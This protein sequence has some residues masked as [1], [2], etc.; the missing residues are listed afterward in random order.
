MKKKEIFL[1]SS[2]HLIYPSLWTKKLIERSILKPAIIDSKIIPHGVDTDIFIPGDK[3]IARDYLKLSQSTFIL[4]MTAKGGFDNQKFDWGMLKKCLQIISEEMKNENILVLILGGL[5][6]SEKIG[7]IMIHE[8]KYQT[9]YEMIVKY[10]QA[11]DIYIHTSKDETFG[12][13]ILEAMSCGLPVVS[14]DSGAIPEIVEDKK[15]GTLIKNR[16]PVEMAK[17]IIFYL[18]NEELLWKMRSAS[19]NRTLTYFSI[20]NMVDK[21]IQ[22]YQEILKKRID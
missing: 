13:S 11:A 4:L 12:M 14:T 21:H 7:K 19:R 15:T 16:D 18:S 8:I 20:Q 9:N 22:Y 1:N 17:K 10:Y 6:R 5:N 3:K 2:I